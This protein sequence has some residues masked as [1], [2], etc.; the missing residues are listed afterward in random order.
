MIIIHKPVLTFTASSVI[1]SA[2]FEIDQHSDSLWYK[3]PLN[4]K[5][6]IVTEQ[7]D[8]FLVGLL[9]LGLKTGRDIQLK[10]PVS[11]RLFYTINHYLIPALCLANPKLK[12]IKIIDAGL[13]EKDLNEGG[14]SG[15]GLSCGVDSFATYYD[16]ISDGG[17]FKIEY[18][19][20]L[21]AGS[22]G[23]SGGEKARRVFFKRLESVKGFASKQGKEIITIDSNLSEILKMNFQSTHTLRNVS[24]ILNL[25]KLFRNYYYASPH[26]FDYYSLNSED[27]GDADILITSLLSTESTCFFASAAHLN[28]IERTDLISNFPATFEYLNVCTNPNNQGARMNCTSCD[29]CLRTA[30]TLDLLGKL[31]LYEQVFDC[32]KFKR[33]RNNFIGKLM[34]TKNKDKFYRDI[35]DLLREKK[36][37]TLSNYYFVGRYHFRTFRKNSKKRIKNKL[38]N[39]R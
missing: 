10:A 17:S 28:R 39:F 7:L 25:Q 27:I 20:Y 23:D 16:H 12:R 2:E 29:K 38:K 35:V 34:A 5:D 14:V 6:Y 19:T 8:S 22:H 18:F 3:F 37:N 26:R 31:H 32:E 30:L 11:A 36:G 13:N 33:N 4:F 21:N 15:T 1:I 24:C 9:F